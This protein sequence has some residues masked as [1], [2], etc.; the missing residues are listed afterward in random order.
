MKTSW[1]SSLKTF[2]RSSLPLFVLALWAACRTR[3]RGRAADT[4]AY[5]EHI[6]PLLKKYCTG[7]HNADDREGELVLAAYDQILAGGEHGAVVAAG[8]SQRSRPDPGAHRQGQAANAARGQLSSPRP[9]KLP[10][11]PPGSTPAQ[12][13]GRRRARSHLLVTPKIAVRGNVVEPIS[14]AACRPTD[15]MLAVARYGRVE[16]VGPATASS[17][18]CAAAPTRSV[19]PRDGALV[20][21]AGGEPGLVGELKLWNV[22]DGALRAVASRTSRQPLRRRAQPRRQAA[23]H[24]QLRSANQALGR[25]HR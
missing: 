11:W 16:L 6:A 18:A 15:G 10:C 14:A 25:G 7:C 5:N 8:D 20:W 9:T 13:S 24:R 22:D 12:G 3:V 4:P 21:A 23:G 19:S 1:R 17:P 2:W